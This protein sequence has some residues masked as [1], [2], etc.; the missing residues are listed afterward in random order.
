M[1]NQQGKLVK[2]ESGFL[3]FSKTDESVARLI[4]GRKERRHK[5]PASGMRQWTSLC[6]L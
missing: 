5:F 3:R 4:R 1:G 2:S 6:I